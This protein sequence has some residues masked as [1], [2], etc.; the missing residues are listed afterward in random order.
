[1]NI[2]AIVRTKSVQRMKS[3]AGTKMMEIMVAPKLNPSKMFIT[4]LR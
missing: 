3:L 1:M 2:D 4:N